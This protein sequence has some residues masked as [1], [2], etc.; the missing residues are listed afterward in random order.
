MALVDSVVTFPWDSNSPDKAMLNVSVVTSMRTGPP[1]WHLLH[2]ITRFTLC[3]LAPQ[4]GGSIGVQASG[5]TAFR[6]VRTSGHRNLLGHVAFYGRTRVLG[7]CTFE[8]GITLTSPADVQV[9]ALD[10][11]T[12]EG[13]LTCWCGV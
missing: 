1:R 2:R 12:V 5:P 8:D 7:D 13:T 10:S 11:L 4:R 6:P 3:R 9:G